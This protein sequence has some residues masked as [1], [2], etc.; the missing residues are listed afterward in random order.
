M[1]FKNLADLS[2]DVNAW[3]PRLP[4]RFDCVVGIPRSGMLV[5]NILALKLGL[6]MTD[7]AGLTE[8]RLIASGKRLKGIDPSGFLSSPRRIL[9]V[10]DSISSG[11][12]MARARDSLAETGKT[13]ELTFG[14]VYVTPNGTNRCETFAEVIPNPRRFEWN[15]LANSDI[16]DFCFDLDGVFC[17]DPTSDENDDGNR[18]R[19]FLEN[20]RPLYLPPYPVGTIVTSRLTKYRPETE[21]WLA[22]WGVEY[23]G[24]E[25]L[26]L[27]SK[28]ERIRTEA[29][30][31]FKA[32]VFRKSGSLLFVESDP[33]QAH[34]IASAAGKFVYCTGDCRLY[35][36]GRVNEV[37]E[38]KRLKWRRKLRRQLRK[39]RAYFQRVFRLISVEKGKG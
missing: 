20:A 30:V 1:N 7:P 3:I 27:E 11:K 5:A 31:P 22:K 33:K 6:P 29:A 26:D 19:Q 23:K 37:L 10:D 36:P 24:L 9:V 35:G 34:A 32:R 4:G 17:V 13:H 25:M 12:A 38:R 28:E 18:Y 16:E 2:R 15:I 14:A 21:A 39:C 8:G